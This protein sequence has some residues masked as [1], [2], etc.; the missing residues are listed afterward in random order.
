[1][2][3]IMSEK[4]KNLLG[5]MQQ[6]VNEPNCPDF[7]GEYP[8]CWEITQD[9]VEIILSYISNLQQRIDKAIEYIKPI[10]VNS[11]YSCSSELEKMLMIL[12]DK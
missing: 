2:I 7:T 1:M 9:E 12:Q 4:V 5:Y 10:Y 11:G 3:K 6:Y 8:L